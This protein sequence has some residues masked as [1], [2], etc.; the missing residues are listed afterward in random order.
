MTRL[1]VSVRPKAEQEAREAAKWYED[2][3]PG[4]GAAFLEI[5]E[6][7]LAGL[8]ENPYRFPV[9]HKN[10]RRALLSRFPYGVFFRILPDRIRVIAI[11]HLSR[12]PNRW[13]DRR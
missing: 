5:V 2:R 6:S 1:P 4:L 9:I 13:Q 3:S 10:V 8:S 12:N 7:V 11:M